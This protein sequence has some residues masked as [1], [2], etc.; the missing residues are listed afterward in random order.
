MLR[1]R[2]DHG[3]PFDPSPA[4]APLCAVIATDRG[5]GQGRTRRGNEGT[6]GAAQG[7]GA[8]A[9]GKIE[10]NEIRNKLYNCA[11]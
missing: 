7:F 5:G 2:G 9:D 1:G 3:P 6:K 8:G 4:G 11:I 10:G